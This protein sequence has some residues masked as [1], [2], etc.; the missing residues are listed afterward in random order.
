[1]IALAAS[2]VSFQTF[3]SFTPLHP[4]RGHI[5]DELVDLRIAGRTLNV[6]ID[7]CLFSP[8]SCVSRILRMKAAYTF[9]VR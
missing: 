2:K 7:V 6:S 4:V 8:P 5:G 3:D 1:V 9:G